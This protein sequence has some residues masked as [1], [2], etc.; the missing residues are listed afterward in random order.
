MIQFALR[1]ETEAEARQAATRYQLCNVFR[2]VYTEKPWFVA[3]IT[4]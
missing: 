3:V 1:Y 2:S 4:K